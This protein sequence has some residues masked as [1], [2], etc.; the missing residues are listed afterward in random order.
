M[1][2]RLPIQSCNQE[3]R[4]TATKVA[5]IIMAG[6]EGRRLHPLTYLIPKPLLPY[7]GK[8]LIDDAIDSCNDWSHKTIVSANKQ[9]ANRIFAHARNRDD[10][11]TCLEEEKLLKIGG[12]LK[13]HINQIEQL[14]VDNLVILVADHIRS[15]DLWNAV[16]THEEKNNDLTL[17]VS[18][19]SSNNN[20]VVVE[21]EFA[22]NYLPACVATDLNTY[23]FS[24]ECVFKWSV[25]R[26]LLLAKNVEIFDLGWNIISEMIAQK[27]YKV[28]VYDVGMWKD[29]GTWKKYLSRNIA[30]DQR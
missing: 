21:N 18:E 10:E 9:N 11:I 17:F 28:G 20:Q 29:V 7:R 30:G 3:R 5:A 2:E 23:S 1:A 15:G 6:G 14:G 27:L 12:A 24:G 16:V 19:A 22:T 13:Y 8:L 25:L 26:N 4:E